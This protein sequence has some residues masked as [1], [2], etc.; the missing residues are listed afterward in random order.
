MK[1]N[2]SP[3]S[4]RNKPAQQLPDYPDMDALKAAEQ[5]VTGLPPLVFAGEAR[6]NG[7]V[8]PVARWRL[9]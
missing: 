9:C 4:W 7:E 1:N 5:R 6:C 3:D 2:W 8:I